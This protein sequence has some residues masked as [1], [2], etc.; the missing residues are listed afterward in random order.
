V[1]ARYFTCNFVVD[2][3]GRVGYTV[4]VMMREGVVLSPNNG[5]KDGLSFF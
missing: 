2:R 5:A 1:I 3:R 4:F